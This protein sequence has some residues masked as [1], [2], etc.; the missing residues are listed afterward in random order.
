[1]IH[2][3]ISSTQYLTMNILGLNG[4]SLVCGAVGFTTCFEETSIVLA[5]VD[6][7]LWKQWWGWV[8]Y[9]ASI[10]DGCDRRGGVGGWPVGESTG[11]AWKKTNVGGG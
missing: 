1:M 4:E 6:G 3:K 7:S 5:Y 8:E 10:V 2:K 11:D 9:G